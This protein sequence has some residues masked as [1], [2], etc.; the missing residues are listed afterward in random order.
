MR[1]VVTV[2]NLRIDILTKQL[3]GTAGQNAV[4]A[5]LMANPGLAENSLYVPE[6]IEL[7]V[8]DLP[9]QP[10]VPAVQPWT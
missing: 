9:A 2:E 1:K 4:E 3:M 10:A 6:G 8:P 5:L 7:V